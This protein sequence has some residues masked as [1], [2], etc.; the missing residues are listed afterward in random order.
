MSHDPAAGEP[1][2]IDPDLA[3]DDP[4]QPAPGRPRRQAPRQRMRPDVLA[5]IALGGALGAPARYEL[6]RVIGVG[7]TGFPWGIFWVNIS[8]SLVLGILIMLLIERRPPSRYLRPFLAVGFLGA[9][10]T[11]STYMVDA[12]LLIKDGHAPTAVAYV[13]GSAVAGLAAVWAGI[14]IGRFGGGHSPASPGATA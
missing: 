7:A 4:D 10:T 11:Y 8:G 6:S 12:D 3:P 5:V 9:Y 1:I 13:L 14:L 2:P